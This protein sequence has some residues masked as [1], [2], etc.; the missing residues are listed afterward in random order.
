[1]AGGVHPALHHAL[2]RGIA[3]GDVLPGGHVRET[4]LLQHREAGTAIGA[5]VGEEGA[6]L[7]GP[8]LGGRHEGAVGRERGQALLRPLLVHQIDDVGDGVGIGLGRLVGRRGALAAGRPADRLGGI[9]LGPAALAGRERGLITIE[10]HDRLCAGEGVVGG[11]LRR[12]D[13]VDDA[14]VIGPV[15]GGAK[16][17][18]ETAH[19]M[20]RSGR[21]GLAVDALVSGEAVDHRAELRTADGRVA[22][23]PVRAG[24]GGDENLL[25]LRPAR[26][27]RV[28]H[29]GG[30]IGEG[31]RAIHGGLTG[32]AVED[33]GHLTAQ[34]LGVRME[35][36]R[37]RAADDALVHGPGDL[38]GGPEGVGHVGEPGRGRGRAAEGRGHADGEEDT[39]QSFHTAIPFVLPQGGVGYGGYRSI[40]KPNTADGKGQRS[41]AEAGSGQTCVVNT[42]C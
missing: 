32:V 28:V 5:G 38:L 11:E 7:R 6:Q 24:D 14:V 41:K 3:H 30:H 12:V 21:R 20:E 29:G 31:G 36:R 15:D 8:D 18:G 1:M 9:R 26:R 10:H 35:R 37:G 25:R 40:E 4:D 34:G 23:E 39:S 19:V 16:L 22:Q 42:M 27:V 13:A 2:R 17:G 33:D